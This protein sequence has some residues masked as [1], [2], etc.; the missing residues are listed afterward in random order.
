[1]CTVSRLYHS[2]DSDGEFGYLTHARTLSGSMLEGGWG[3]RH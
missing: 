2:L 1:M 3:S